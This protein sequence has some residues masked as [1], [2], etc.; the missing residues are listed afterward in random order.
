MHVALYQA[1]NWTPPQFGHVPLLVGQNGQ[2]L[3]KRDADI[4]ISF[5]RDSGILPS[6]LLNYAALLGWSHTSRSEVFTLEDMEK[7][8]G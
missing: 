2:K 4:D 6:T 8:V 1:F 3:S 7:I 5:Y